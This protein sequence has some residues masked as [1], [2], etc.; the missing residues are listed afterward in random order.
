MATVCECCPTGTDHLPADRPQEGDPCAAPLSRVDHDGDGGRAT[1][2]PSPYKGTQQDEQRTRSVVARRKDAFGAN[3]EQKPSVVSIAAL[4]QAD[5]QFRKVMEAVQASCGLNLCYTDD[6][7]L[8]VA[9]D[10]EYVLIEIA[11]DSGAGDHVA[12]AVDAPG[13]TIE[14]SAG[15]RRG[16]NFV[17]AGGHKMP[18]KGQVTLQMLAPNGTAMDEQIST[19]F[20]V[21]DVTRP[22]WSVSKVCDS[23]YKVLF[24]KDSATILDESMTPVC[25][26]QRQGGLYVARMRLRN[27]KWSG[28][29]RQGNK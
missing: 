9:D 15:S 2:A 5:D 13:Y 10:E 18:N 3:G 17:G 14:A 11:L 27:P 21:A 8:N 12:S 1:T 26:F 28:F 29:S 20:Q 24:D 16:Q 22:L 19:I 6:A 7:E 23:G 25:A 4:P